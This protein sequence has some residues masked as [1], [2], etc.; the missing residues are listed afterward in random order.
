MLNEYL[1]FGGYP[2]VIFEEK[3]SEKIKIIDEIYRSYLEKDISYLI[4][5][6]RIDFFSSL[7]KILAGQIGRLINYRIIFS[8]RDISSNN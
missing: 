1:N 2:R 5:S 8:F 7:I 3:L 4:K 6:E